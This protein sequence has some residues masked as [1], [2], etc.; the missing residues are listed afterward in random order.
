MEHRTA[1]FS[2]E[3]TYWNASFRLEEVNE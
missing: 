3:T 2:T 1:H